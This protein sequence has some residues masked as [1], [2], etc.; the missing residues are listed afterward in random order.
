MKHKTIAIIGLGQIGQRH[1]QSILRINHKLNLYL[2]D[3]NQKVLEFIQK[4]YLVDKKI[5]IFFESELNIKN[6]KIDILLI[7]T[8]ADVR[9]KVLKKVLKKI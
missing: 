7:C 8:T 5:N 6:L 2:F 3:L 1:L 9:L 4:N